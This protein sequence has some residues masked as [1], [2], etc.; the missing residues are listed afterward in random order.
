VV[1]RTVYIV[2]FM[3]GAGAL[4]AFAYSVR[5]RNDNKSTASLPA[6]VCFGGTAQHVLHCCTLD[7]PARPCF[8]VELQPSRSVAWLNSS[9]PSMTK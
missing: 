5:E 1:W 8:T 2:H 4:W 9:Q 7:N 6:Y 3:D